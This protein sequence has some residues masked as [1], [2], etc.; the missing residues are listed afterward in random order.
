MFICAIAGCG[1]T[2][3]P[4]SRLDICPAC[5]N[6]SRYWRKPERGLAAILVRKHKLDV[7]KNRMQHL[8]ETTPGYT[9]LKRELKKEPKK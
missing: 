7:W 9:K 6:V 8:A 1:K 2:L 5:Q 3:S 4:R